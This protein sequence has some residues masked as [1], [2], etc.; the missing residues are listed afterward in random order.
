MKNFIIEKLQNETADQ[1]LLAWWN[2]YDSQDLGGWLILDSL[3]GWAEMLGDEPVEFAKRIY[4]GKVENWNDEYFWLNGYGNLESSN[5]LT[6]GDTPL[7]LGALA[8]WLIDEQPNYIEDW[9]NEWEEQNETE[10]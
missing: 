4:F 3:E 5:S 10:E 8:Q 9:V 2:E 7:D 6:S 1:T